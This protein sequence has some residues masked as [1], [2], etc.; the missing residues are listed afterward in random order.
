MMYLIYAQNLD[1]DT[2]D[3][4]RLSLWSAAI[5]HLDAPFPYHSKYLQIDID[6]DLV[7]CV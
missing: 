1:N 6:D 4:L 3:G 2:I 7:Y 5:W